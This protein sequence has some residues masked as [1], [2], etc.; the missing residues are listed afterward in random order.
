[1][2]RALV[3]ATTHEEI[4]R[5]VV[6][7]LAD[8]GP[9]RFAWVG[10]RTPEGTLE[11]AAVE[12][13]DE[14]AVD[15]APV[16]LASA[17]FDADEVVTADAETATD[18][19]VTADGDASLAAIPFRY[20]EREFG[21]L[22]VAADR[23]GAFDQ[24]ER[25]VLAELGET[26]AYASAAVD[27]RRALVSDTVVELEFD[28]SDTD[29]FFI[30][31]SEEIACEFVVEGT[32]LGSDGTLLYY[33]TTSGAP[34]EEMTDRLRD[35]DAVEHVRVV[36]E[37]EENCLLELARVDATL[38][39]SLADY[40]G[41]IQSAVANEDDAR[42]VVEVP[43]DADV[44][45][46]VE[47]FKDSYPN[48]ELLAQRERDRTTRAVQRMSTALDDELTDR[49]RSALEAA[50]FAGYFEWPRSSTGEEVADSLGVTSPT[51]HQHLR[52]SQSKLLEAFFAD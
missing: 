6:D 51:F 41:A 25:T 13:S 27:S 32:T 1:L 21:V 47:A 10:E 39:M 48:A 35:Y 28:T 38:V 42:L 4:Q 3:R 37:R 29:H 12:K 44:R 46:T 34:V 19:K 20:R 23:E 26:I 45:G 14:A 7:R 11:T 40:G 43:G 8:A 24:R 18:A 30:D 33:I 9:Y 17:A 16:K 36:A 2:D 15:D 49:Q 22:V 5:S 50:H 52:R 31:I